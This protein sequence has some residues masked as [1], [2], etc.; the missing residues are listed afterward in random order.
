MF[1]CSCFCTSNFRG[2]SVVYYTHMFKDVSV[3]CVLLPLS[4]YGRTH[5]WHTGIWE[6]WYQ[7]ERPVSLPGSHIL[8]KNKIYKWLTGYT[9][10]AVRECE[11]KHS[12]DSSVLNTEPLW[13]HLIWWRWPSSM[14]GTR[15]TDPKSVW[16]ANVEELKQDISNKNWESIEDT[17]SAPSTGDYFKYLHGRNGQISPTVSTV[18]TWFLVK[19]SSSS[20]SSVL[21]SSMVSPLAK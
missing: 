20:S 6:W 3:V 21:Y 11:N 16:T 12:K 2:V 1:T 13:L 5:R 7:A 8:N 19:S 4:S 9:L 10:I 17:I 18:A 15:N 14:F